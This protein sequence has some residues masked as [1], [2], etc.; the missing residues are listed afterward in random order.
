MK[1]IKSHFSYSK[2]QR[3]GIFLLVVL[4]FAL[5]GFILYGKFGKQELYLLD[6]TSL[7]LQIKLD[8][9]ERVAYQPKKIYPFNPNYLSDY[10]AYQLGMSVDEIDRL[11]A[12]RKQ[13]KYVNSSKEFQNITK[14]SDS[15]LSRLSPF[16]KFPDWVKKKSD[17][18]KKSAKKIKKKRVVKDINKATIEELVKINGIAEK[19][20]Q[21]I[22]KYR[23]LLGGF[24]VDAQLDEVWGI[25]PDVLV[26]LKQEF[27]VL[28]PPKIKP[29]DVNYASIEELKS[30]VYINYKQAKSIVMYRSK[31]GEIQNLAELKTLS[32]FPVDKYELI[33]LYLHAH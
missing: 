7:K 2:S 1:K 3:N 15:L 25:P 4:V 14:V 33:S 10:R 12:Y 32:D 24:T 28:S 5:Q 19:R 9:L 30:I 11:L 16:F 8:S 6:E 23:D 17:Q 18:P 20:A 26:A 13:N 29:I 31:V 21:T 27:K 22:L